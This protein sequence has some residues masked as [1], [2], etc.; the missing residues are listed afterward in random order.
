MGLARL[1]DCGQS[2]PLWAKLTKERAP[3][4]R[5]RTCGAP[6]YPCPA[7]EY[8]YL[9]C[10]TTATTPSQ[11]RC[12]MTTETGHIDADAKAPDPEGTSVR[13]RHESTLPFVGSGWFAGLWARGLACSGTAMRP[14]EDFFTT[15]PDG[16]G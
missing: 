1:V 16:A 2:A 10:A 3:F 11:A 13:V 12:W 9:I 8:T 4:V 15:R 7:A 5:L 6:R 14:A